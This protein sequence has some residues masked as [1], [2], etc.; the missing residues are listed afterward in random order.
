MSLIVQC[1]VKF[2]AFLRNLNCTLKSKFDV[3]IPSLF[4]WFI[5]LRPMWLNKR[6]VSALPWGITKM[7]FASFSNV[8]WRYSVSKQSLIWL[9]ACQHL[10][11]SVVAVTLGGNGDVQ[12]SIY[13]S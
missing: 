7:A 11:N 13:F 9:I 8:D 5:F 10:S 12:K 6:L 4:L 3:E 1:S 2:I